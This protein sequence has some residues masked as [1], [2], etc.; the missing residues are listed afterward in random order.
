[1]E[2]EPDRRAGTALKAECTRKGMGVGSSTFRQ[3]ERKFYRVGL[4]L[5]IQR[6][7]K[8]H[9]DQDLCAPPFK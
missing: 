8:G 3:M 7:L 9:E 1:M 5:L 2:S 6:C 4:G